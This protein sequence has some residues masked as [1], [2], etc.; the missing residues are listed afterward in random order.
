MNDVATIKVKVPG[1][2]TEKI[3][4]GIGTWFNGLSQNNQTTIAC[5]AIVSLSGIVVYGIHKGCGF[6]KYPD[7]TCEITNTGF[8]A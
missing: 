5:T 7:G 4:E 6:K 1:C 2:G 8:V 3:V